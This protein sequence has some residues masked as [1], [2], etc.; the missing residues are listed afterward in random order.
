MYLEFVKRKR[1]NRDFR[2]MEKI[3]SLNSKKDGVRSQ[4]ISIVK[5]MVCNF[6]T[7]FICR[8]K[9]QNHNVCILIYT[10]H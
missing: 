9:F 3:S 2:N 1:I 10:V 8:S 4:G 6:P 7:Y 5:E